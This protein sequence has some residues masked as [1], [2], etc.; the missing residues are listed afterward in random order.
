MLLSTADVPWELGHF[1]A[2]G[3]LSLLH[4]MAISVGALPFG[5]VPVSLREAKEKPGGGACCSGVDIGKSQPQEQQEIHTK[6]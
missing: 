4:I 5:R 1:T 3:K 2:I 6:H